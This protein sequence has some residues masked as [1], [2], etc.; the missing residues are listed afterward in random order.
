MK[1]LCFTTF[2][3]VNILLAFGFL[4]CVFRYVFDP[5][6]PDYFSSVTGALGFAALLHIHNRKD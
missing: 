3:L 2:W 1:I 4:Y 6:V 5:N